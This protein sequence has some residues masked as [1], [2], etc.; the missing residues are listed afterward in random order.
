[1]TF[2]SLNHNLLVGKPKYHNLHLSTALFKKMYLTNIWQCCKI[3]D[4]LSEWQRIISGVLQGSILG[5]LL[6][7]IFINDIFLYIESSDLCNYF[8]K[9]C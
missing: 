5:S 2:D 1:M 3:G 8:M 6:F 9:P 4:S 7:D